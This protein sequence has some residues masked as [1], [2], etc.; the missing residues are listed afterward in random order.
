MCEWWDALGVPNSLSSVFLS[1][2]PSPATRGNRSAVR[3][4]RPPGATN[5]VFDHQTFPPDRED[6]GKT[7]SVEEPYYYT[8][9]GGGSE[10]KAHRPPNEPFY[11]TPFSGVNN[12]KK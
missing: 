4:T 10:Q 8:L 6:G 7:K 12:K 1:P 11:T 3:S 2:H 9:D 5:Q